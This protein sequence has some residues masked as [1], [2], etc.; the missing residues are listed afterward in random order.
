MWLRPPYQK[1]IRR[2]IFMNLSL[3]PLSSESPT[4]SASPQGQNP[5]ADAEKPTALDNTNVLSP[6]HDVLSPH[7]LS[8]ALD[9][10]GISISSSAPSQGKP[11][12][13]PIGNKPKSEVEQVAFSLKTFVKFIDEQYSTQ[14]FSYVQGWFQT[15]VKGGMTSATAIELTFQK[16][17]ET[18]DQKGTGASSKGLESGELDEIMYQFKKLNETLSTPAKKSQ[19]STHFAQAVLNSV[20]E[21]T[22]D[23][24]HTSPLQQENANLKAEIAK[25]RTENV[26]LKV[27]NARVQA[28]LKK[29]EEVQK[30]LEQ[31]LQETMTP[32]EAVLSY[33]AEMD[34]ADLFPRKPLPPLPKPKSSEDLTQAQL[35]GFKQKGK[36]SQSGVDNRAAM[37]ASL[38]KP[39]NLK[40]TQVQSGTSKPT[41]NESQSSGDARSNLLA[42]IRLGLNKDV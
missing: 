12:R 28:Q 23:S 20:P 38:I 3:S 18:I 15:V 39:R 21:G 42:D 30:A 17:T 19:G 37:L 13:K 16:L 35:G 31:E 11:V 34:L 26:Q 29:A 24:K 14:I 5:K 6:A 27:E 8:K 32:E 25:L 40:S 33:A 22:A 9:F 2:D 1:N 10:S 36:L 41:S 4:K 7:S